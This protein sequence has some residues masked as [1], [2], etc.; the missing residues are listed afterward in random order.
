MKATAF[1]VIITALF[2]YQK[3]DEIRG[4]I[5]TPPDY[6][7]AHEVDVIMY[8]TTWCGYCAK[9]RTLLEELDVTYFEYDIENSTEG[10]QQFK[11]L[12]GRGVPVLQIGGEVV[13]GYNP[14]RIKTLVRKI[15]F[16]T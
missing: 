8:G 14:S 2:L 13:K 6:A 15:D 5:F 9:T 3:Q 10:Y 12:G 16:E 1:L 7:E 11:A 4:F